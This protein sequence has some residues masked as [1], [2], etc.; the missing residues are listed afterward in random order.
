VSDIENHTGSNQPSDAEAVQDDTSVNE[1]QQAFPIIA[2]GAS[3]GGLESLESFFEN[4]PPNTGVTFVVLQHLS[5]DFKSVMDEL[6]GRRTDIPIQQAADGL[7][8]EKDCIYL[9]PP[10]QEA[11]LTDG[12]FRL[13]DKE[14]KETLSLPIDHFFRSLAQE[15]GEDSVA[16]VLSGSGS[17][18]SR[19]VRD[20]SAVGGLVIAESTESA[21]FDGMPSSSIATGIV[22]MVL[23]PKEMPTAILEHIVGLSVN[24]R[25]DLAKSKGKSPTGN[26]LIFSLLNSEF[27][28][29]FSH[30]KT[31]TVARRVDRRM[32]MMRAASIEDYAERL[33]GDR[34]ELGALYHDLLIGV[35]RFFRDPGAFAKLEHEVVP[36]IIERV[37]PN[38][39]IRVWISGCATGEEAYSVAM[40]FHEQLRAAK[41]SPHLKI[42]ATDVHRAS[43]D[44]AGSGTYPASSFE[45]ISDSRINNYFMP[46]GDGYNPSV[47]LRKS[48]VF[49]EHNLLRDAPFT[50]LDLIV[51]RNLLIYFQPP[52]QKK[53]I[54]LFHFGLKTGGHMMLGPSESTGDLT[55]EFD[56]V[57][58]HWKIYKKR[59]DI[60]LPTEVRYPIG[61]KNAPHSRSG[62][63][64]IQ[65]IRSTSGF[66]PGLLGAYDWM[67]GRHMPPAVLIDDNHQLIHI[68]GS[69]EK[70]MVMRGGRPNLDVLD[71]FQEEIRT[72]LVG[73][74]QRVKKD[75]KP[76]IY[77]GVRIKTG[78]TAGMYSIRVE[79]VENDRAARQQLL[80]TFQRVDE[81]E[82]AIKPQIGQNAEV[83]D[84]SAMSRDRMASLKNEL[85]YT[86]QNLQATVEELETSNEELQ[87]TNEELVASNEELQSTNEELHS[88]NEELYTVNAE[89]QKKINDLTRLTADLDNL[90][91][92][93][94]V[95]TVF[96]DKDLRIR[97]FTPQIASVFRL[98]LQDIG[99]PLN[100]FAHYI[101]RPN[102][103][104]EIRSVLETGQ[105]MEGEVRGQDGRWSYMR[106]SPY[107]SLDAVEGIVMTLVDV[108]K[109]KQTQELLTTAVQDRERFLAMLSHELRN[110]ISAV[111]SASHLLKSDRANQEVFESAVSV[112]QRQSSH[113]GRLLDDL[114][115]V[116]RMTQNKLELR[117]TDIDLRNVIIEAVEATRPS[118]TQH[119]QSF[120]LDV[121][122]SGLPVFGDKNRL[123][124]VIENVIGNAVKY[125]P[126]D[127]RIKLTA[128]I[129][130][131]QVNVIIVDEGEGIAA[132]MLGHIFEPF[133]QL[134]RTH[135]Q[136]DGGMGVGLSLVK[137]IV[138]GHEGSVIAA[139]DGI[140]KGSQF[141]IR[142]PLRTSGVEGQSSSG[143]NKGRDS[144]SRDG[145]DSN[146]TE[147]LRP[148]RVVDRD[149]S[150]IVILEDQKDN[151]EMLQALLQIEGFEIST[152]KNAEEGLR[153]ILETK[154][155]AALIDVGLPDCDGYSVVSEIR[156]KLGDEMFLVALTGHGQPDDVNAA[157][158]A[159]FD[160][161]LIKPLDLDLL[162]RIL[163][164]KA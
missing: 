51:C 120:E 156:E 134:S 16:V 76:I 8:L 145:K 53:A 79:A 108:D 112:I 58:S 84:V 88:V 63:A 61:P 65:P 34:E 126:R 150:T 29:D 138:E 56:T 33:V 10:K 114:L 92:S 37:E 95:A 12:C 91:G 49:A 164:P 96:L 160:Q 117:K 70:F 17:D 111:V 27:G 62:S 69:A 36:K 113:I 130:Q 81:N 57:D 59:R 11:I 74:I 40:L 55:D 68:F 127:S 154:P 44:F 86:K 71:A 42:F 110:P 119:S 28:I 75:L 116:S 35:T 9:I 82:V 4:V 39:E 85:A 77:T 14:P 159:G 25:R 148:S 94:D 129:S 139:S 133:R 50:K 13:R 6:L 115:D 22:D 151:R 123:Q 64:L 109:L 99:R 128:R 48:I 124:Q 155:D 60:R 103:I 122:S 158:K 121:G 38:E 83:A 43:L 20:V 146:S 19:G 98:E 161:H 32:S 144:Q 132:S 143:T 157:I 104:P 18:G 72:T 5:P 105:P 23:E 107:R 54:S 30:Y 78:D 2:L 1:T 137:F 24:S 7:R 152:G 163:R 45:G 118:V 87:A 141:T 102:L 67:L 106:V 97:K 46:D 26:A 3:A 142:L 66:D 31:T 135:D 90:I 89:Y 162:L 93:T 47:E 136:Q 15:A 153:L 149:L 73:A 80:I 100:I 41:R 131:G 140:G 101:D 21:K 147:L 125:S 52:A